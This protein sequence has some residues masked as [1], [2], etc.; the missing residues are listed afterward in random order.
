[1][2]VLFKEQLWT[3][4]KNKQW[5]DIEFSVQNHLY[6]AHKVI[7]SAR[8]PV[9]AAMFSGKNATKCSRIKVQDTDA[10]AFEHFLHFLY[11]G[12]FDHFGGGGGG[13]SGGGGVNYAELLKVAVAYQVETLRLLCLSAVEEIDAHLLTSFAISMKPDFE[14]SLKRPKT[15]LRCSAQ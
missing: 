14:S 3:A 11:T 13:G 10:A 8:S 15:E 12:E 6:P 4:A 9:L 2:D 7:V 1:M 5:T